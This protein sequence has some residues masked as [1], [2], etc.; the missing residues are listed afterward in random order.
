MNDQERYSELL[1]NHT[2]E[3]EVSRAT[4]DICFLL[5]VCEGALDDISSFNSQMFLAAKTG[6][7]Y[8]G[9]VDGTDLYL[10]T[11]SRADARD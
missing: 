4:C 6:Q 10:R 11:E 3:N 7:I 8:A 2:Y 5:C 1:S 9:S